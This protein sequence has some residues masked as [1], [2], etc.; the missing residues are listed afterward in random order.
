MSLRRLSSSVYYGIE[1][2]NWY[3]IGILSFF[4]IRN[5]LKSTSRVYR[6]PMSL[7]TLE[8]D[9]LVYSFLLQLV[10]FFGVDLNNYKIKFEY[11]TQ[12]Q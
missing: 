10:S 3:V 7:R 5:R 4:F 11:S 6:A 9:N 12:T 1:I 2:L 8:F